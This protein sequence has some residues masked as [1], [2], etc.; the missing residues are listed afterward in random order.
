M[1]YDNLNMSDTFQNEQ[2]IQQY[3]YDVEAVNILSGDIC[4][5]I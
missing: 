2:Q 1:V 4:R 5:K 3:H